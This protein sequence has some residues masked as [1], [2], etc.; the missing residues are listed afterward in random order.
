MVI[1]ELVGIYLG[2]DALYYNCA[3]R[4]LTS[5]KSA[6]PGSSMEPSGVIQGYPTLT[7][8]EFLLRIS[9][10]PGRRIFLT[11]PRNRFFIRDLQLPPLPLEDAL[12]SVQSNLSLTCHLSLDEIYHD[13]YLGRMPGFSICFGN[14]DMR[15]PWSVFFP[16]AWGP[17][18]G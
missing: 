8:R 18:P 5:W 10:K 4:T 7:L 3:V 2:K 6:I 11:F 16:F 12:L 14:S 13:I 17:A 1:K 15:N 9:P